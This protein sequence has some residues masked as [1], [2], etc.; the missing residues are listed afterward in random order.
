MSIFGR[1]R[2]Q[3]KSLFARNDGN[4]N[5]RDSQSGSAARGL[6]GQALGHVF[7]ILAAL[8]FWICNTETLRGIDTDGKP[9]AH[10]TAIAAELELSEQGA[11]R[12][13]M[14]RRAS[15]LVAKARQTDAT[16]RRRSKAVQCRGA[17]IRRI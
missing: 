17:T 8:S 1:S 10:G 15:D 3:E 5:D 9:T 2:D 12:A 14:W 13:Y 11:G 6:R 7:R 16:H 4:A